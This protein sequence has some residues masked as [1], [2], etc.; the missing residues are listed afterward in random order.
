MDDRSRLTPLQKDGLRELGNIGTGKAAAYLSDR[1][2]QDVTIGIP[3]VDI[4]S[5]PDSMEDVPDLLEDDGGASKHIGVLCPTDTVTGGVLLSLPRNDHVQFLHLL[6][7]SSPDSTEHKDFLTTVQTIADCY[8]QGI[9]QLLSTDVNSGS[10]QM[11]YL[12]RST[13]MIHIASTIYKDLDDDQDS[14]PDALIIRTALSV[15]D[16]IHGEIVMLVRVSETE[17]ILS[18]LEE[19]VE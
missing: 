5:L 12:P 10:P 1:L 4:I 18:A 13:L 16:D 7:E 8:L 6:E 9:N 2:E 3:E 17:K 19:L 14:L 15:G 11:M